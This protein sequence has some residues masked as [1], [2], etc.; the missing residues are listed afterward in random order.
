VTSSTTGDTTTAPSEDAGT[1]LRSATLATYAAFAG[2]G[3]AFANWGARIPQVRD[4]LHLTPAGLGLVLLAIAVG[5]VLALPLSGT[6]VHRFGPRRTVAATATLVALA[7]ATVAVGYLAGVVPSVVGL[8]LFG[9][10]IGAWDVAMNVHG[11]AVEQRLGR[12]IMPRFHAG[13]SLGTV[14]G[15]LTGAAAVALHVPVT[16]HLLLVAVA[17]G[18]AVPLGARRFLPDPDLAAAD[19]DR[20]TD[21]PRVGGQHG[22]LA[23]WRE[24]RTL[25]IGLCVLAFSFAE[26][27]GNDWISV[28][29]IDGHGVPA[30]LG[31]LAFA[32][33]LMA[34]TAVRWFGAALLDRHGRVPVVRVLAGISLAGLLLFVFAPNA[35]LAFLGALL[36][37]AGASLGFPVGMSAAADDPARAAGR[38]SAVA[39]IGYCAFL[40]GPPLIGFLG[41]HVG[42]LR[43]LT[44]VVVLLALGALTSGSM[45]RR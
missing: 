16:A 41:D 23:A 43:A 40:T 8:F 15:A 17:I 11:A 42:V 32:A 34:M 28:A 26:G 38:V 19:R 35:P 12:S 7:L 29:T 9:L 5:S 30:A 1:A 37:G 2:C 4:R 22:A 20:T 24:P 13:Y 6:V 3:F 27:A 14:A 36:W 10:G 31:T 44:A 33:F 45:G 18:I 21:G 39:S 25:L